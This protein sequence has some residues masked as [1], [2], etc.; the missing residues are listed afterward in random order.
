MAN[1]SSL[2]HELRERIAASSSTPPNIG[3]DD[4][5]EIRFRAVLPNLL[6]AYVVPSSSANEREVIAVLKLLTHTAKNFPGVFFH[7]RAAAVL[8]L[9]GRILPF[10]AEPAFRSRHGVIFETV[11]SLLSL[12][13]TGDRDAYRQ[14][15][16]DTMLMVEDLLYIA[17]LCANESSITVS[18]KV[19]L[20]CFCES[21]N[22]ISS[23]PALL[24]DLPP[25]SKAAD[26]L[27]VLINLTGKQRWQPF[28]TWV[29]RL[30][31]KCL[32]EGTLY[33]EGLINV[34]FVSAACTLL[35]YG[36]AD[37]HMACF[38]FARIIGTVVDY[39]IVPSE[40]LI[41]LISTILSEDVEGLPVFRYIFRCLEITTVSS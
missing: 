24:S 37:L 13:R 10:F 32:T 30:I 36:E 14:F 23:D 2:V 39:E 1:L 18:R 33:V 16:I 9:I 6:H 19:S 25:C 40:K 5:L 3:D 27:G 29:I 41:Q 34:S 21:F 11:G 4:A 8:P 35:C 7:G 15:F 28:A 31:S 22:G 17:S 12:L 26:G 20:K 38:D